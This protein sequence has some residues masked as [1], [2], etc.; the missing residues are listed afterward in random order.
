MD[1]RKNFIVHSNVGT[2]KTRLAAAIGIEACSRGKTVRFFRTAALLNQPDEAQKRGEA[3]RFF[4]QLA[5][6]HL[7]SVTSGGTSP[8]SRPGQSSCFRLTGDMLLFLC[9]VFELLG[10]ILFVYACHSSN[11][12]SP[13]DLDH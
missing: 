7:L 6:I 3:N 5:Q 10:I 13:Y 11:D 9:K 12:F 4:K 2:G 1:D 8:L